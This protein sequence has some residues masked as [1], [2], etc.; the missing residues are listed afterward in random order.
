MEYSDS[1]LG[2]LHPRRQQHLETFFNALISGD[3]GYATGI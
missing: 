2:I 3:E 1:Q